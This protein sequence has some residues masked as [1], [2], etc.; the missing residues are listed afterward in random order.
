METPPYISF[1]TFKTLLYWLE[2]E[3]VPLRIDRSFWKEKFSGANGSK[4]MGALRFL[5]LLDGDKPTKEL[6]IL[7]NSSLGDE[8]SQIFVN[9]LTKSYRNIPFEE[10][11]RA[12]PN[13]IKEWFRVYPIDGHTLR[14]ATTFFINA[15]REAQIPMSNS[16]IKMT[17]SRRINSQQ[18]IK[19]LNAASE[20][21]ATINKRIPAVN[22]LQDGETLRNSTT[23]PLSN[24]GTVVVDVAVNL[25]S[26]SEED[27]SFVFSIVD[28]A[29]S[30]TSSK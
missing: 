16:I 19:S 29:K 6:E 14:K 23:I 12:T 5:G 17:K 30:Y 8:R 22:K 7:V 1:N 2:K 21:I 13:M 28:L 27:R 10:L 25:F 4:L 11:A 18:Q 24:G 20:E 15:A 26:L 3:G 9:I